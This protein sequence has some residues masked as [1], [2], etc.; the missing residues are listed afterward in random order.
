MIRDGTSAEINVD[1]EANMGEI[2]SKVEYS[3]NVRHRANH[4]VFLHM[5]TTKYT[6]QFS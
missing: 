5:V 4:F 6:T 2:K 3:I 1:N